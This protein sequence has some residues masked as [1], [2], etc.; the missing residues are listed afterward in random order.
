M[1]N[2]RSTARLAPE[3]VITGT[4]QPVTA[5]NSPVTDRPKALPY[6]RVPSKRW[7]RFLASSASESWADMTRGLI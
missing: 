2:C 4:A 6:L 5:G 7:K 1:E 3:V